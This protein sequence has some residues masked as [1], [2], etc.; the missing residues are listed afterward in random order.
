MKHYKEEKTDSGSEEKI[1][2]L[3][4]LILLLLPHNVSPQFYLNG[5][6]KY[7]SF[8]IPQGSESFFALNFNGDSFNDFLILNN[9]NKTAS[10]LL[11]ESEGKFKNGYTNSAFIS[12]N[13]LLPIYDFYGKTSS[14]VYASRIINTV[15]FV[16]YKG[17]GNPTF[18]KKIRFSS[19][20]EKLSTADVDKNGRTEVLVSGASFEGLSIIY[21]TEK[22]LTEKKIYPKESFSQSVFIDLNHDG[23]P[24]IVAFEVSTYSLYFFYNN[25]RGGFRLERKVNLQ[26]SIQ[27]LQVVDFNLDSYPDLLFTFGNSIVIKYGDPFSSL[28]QQSIVKT[29]YK[30][31]KVIYGDFNRDGKIGIVYL[32]KEN[33]SVSILFK[34]NE[35]ALQ[36]EVVYFT[37][38]GLVDIIP[39]YSKF[40]D[41]FAV[42]NN[43]GKI[44]LFSNLI[45]F[46]KYAKLYFGGKAD[47]ISS[48]DYG[49]NG[50]YDI[51]FINSDNS[52]FNLVLRDNSGIPTILYSI[53][54]FLGYQNYR[55][56]DRLPY[57]KTFYFYNQSDRVIELL[58]V[59]LESFTYKRNYIYTGGTILDLRITNN[60]DE[61]KS[62]IHV[63]H[64]KNGL[65]SSSLYSYKDFH[66]SEVT[67][68]SLA[69]NVISA[70]IS[71][72]SSIYHWKDEKEKLSLSVINSTGNQ[73]SKKIFTYQKNKSK[74]DVKIL[75]DI[76]NSEKEILVTNLTQNGETAALFAKEDFYEIIKANDENKDFFAPNGLLYGGDFR[77]HSLNKLFLYLPDK[78]TLNSVQYLKKKNRMVVSK[79]NRIDDLSSFI[80]QRFS[81]NNYYV[82]YSLTEE[83]CLI[84]ERL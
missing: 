64:I 6:C 57:L 2:K 53:P 27:N 13:S 82:I 42:L 10:T 26:Q 76:F 84:F 21:Q 61:Q 30:P 8:E 31:S 16:S 28:E 71:E 78:K 19:Y 43:K 20:P 15:G 81:A 4:F 36:D 83:K 34:Q 24:D 11:G 58:D 37:Q 69:T 60:Q 80:V 70:K 29:K 74:P 66:Y 54:L 5:F 46:S 50:I 67:S 9:S 25:T 38:P 1:F 32:S 49:D 17:K 22:G 14:H 63:A 59:D 44:Y 77:P 72:N 7:D 56:D 40:I 51:S 52:T 73:N 47:K 65:L 55:V 39:F 23:Y 3:F 45:S 33:S 62:S 41:G 35:D 75:F 18:G 79:I 48:F 12:I 68:T